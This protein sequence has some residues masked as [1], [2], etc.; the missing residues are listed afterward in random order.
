M[1]WRNTNS[2]VSKCRMKRLPNDNFE[3]TTLY[4]MVLWGVLWIL[5]IKIISRHS[6]RC[7][8]N[9]WFNVWQCRSSIY[10]IRKEK[11]F[12]TLTLWWYFIESGCTN[13][14]LIFPRLETAK[15][16]IN[17]PTAEVF[18]ELIL[19]KDSPTRG[20]MPILVRNK[21]YYKVPN[22]VIIWRLFVPIK[23][24]SSPEN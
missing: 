20:K 4:E 2:T 17:T 1:V 10:A 3:Q 22:R 12:N 7:L 5:D 14:K 13:K 9:D 23:M 11:P 19:T 15:W 8:W 6:R 18:W 21:K 16:E 24:N